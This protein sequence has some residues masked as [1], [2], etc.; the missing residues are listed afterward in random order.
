MRELVL[1]LREHRRAAGLTLAELG[2]ATMYSRAHISEALSGRRVPSWDLVERM[3]RATS[4]TRP[5]SDQLEKLRELWTSARQA[6]GYRPD[7][8]P[9]RAMTN[10]LPP[11][12]H[13]V[14]DAAAREARQRTVLHD[15]YAL[16]GFPSVRELAEA[17]RL[18]RSAVHRAVTG[19]SLAG[20]REVADGLVARLVPEER[21]EWAAR[22]S[23][24]FDEASAPAED[25]PRF[26][27]LNA[28]EGQA[29][30]IAGTISDFESSLRRMRNMIAHGMV[31][32]SPEIA[33]QVLL[34]A[35]T[36]EQAPNRPA[37][38]AV[39]EGHLTWNGTEW[40]KFAEDQMSDTVLFKSDN[41]EGEAADLVRPTSDKDQT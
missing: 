25:T 17:I 30:E 16:T 31:Q 9:A 29:V 13:Q 1:R 39:P 5:T 6:T 36:L 3:A 11:G 24:V 41:A 38:A 22:V 23:S 35:A 19:Q 21:D 37:N 10:V 26:R 33:A 18:S 34:L 8:A 32:T 28:G 4:P 12:A 27:A 15:L 40:V 2:V 7:S 14:M 20:A